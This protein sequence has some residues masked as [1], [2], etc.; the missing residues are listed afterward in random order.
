VK[1]CEVFG[2][3]EKIIY[4]YCTDWSLSRYTRSIRFAETKLEDGALVPAG[5]G[6]VF[7]D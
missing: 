3:H 4:N 2:L 5:D 7:A 1:V 6:E